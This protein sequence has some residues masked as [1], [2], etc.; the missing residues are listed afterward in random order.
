MV[1]EERDHVLPYITFLVHVFTM[2]LY[3]ENPSANLRFC[4]SLPDGRILASC[5]S[6]NAVIIADAEGNEMGKLEANFSHPEGIAVAEDKIYVVDR[7]HHCI[8][9][10]KTSSLDHESTIGSPGSCPGQFNQ[11]V[12]IAVSTV[13][14]RIWIADNENHRVQAL[15]EDGR[16]FGSYGTEPGQFFCPCGIALYVHPVHGELVIVS[17]WGG[18]RV[19]VLRATD[20]SVYSVFGGVNHAHSVAVDGGGI[21]YVSNYAERKV[22]RFSITGEWKAFSKSVVSL[23]AQGLLVFQNGLHRS[24]ENGKKKRRRRV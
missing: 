14:K 7:H 22:Q 23:D 16:I 1:N 10:F 20:G 6:R 15:G 5:H 2:S 12:G 3:D 9:V 8:H 21:V 4:A 18:G 11:P 13:D 19:Q 17:E 24:E